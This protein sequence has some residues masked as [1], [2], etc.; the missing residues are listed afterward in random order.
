MTEKG[1]LLA[2]VEFNVCSVAGS[3]A[4]SWDYGRNVLSMLQLRCAMTPRV[5]AHRVGG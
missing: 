4:T 5:S 2:F 3:K 1:S